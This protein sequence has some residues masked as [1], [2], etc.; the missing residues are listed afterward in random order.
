VRCRAVV[1][2]WCCWLGEGLGCGSRMGVWRREIVVVG[3]R[4]LYLTEGLD[5]GDI[6]SHHITSHHITARPAGFSVR[7]PVP[8]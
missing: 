1:G 8:G 5:V 4:D 6:T 3:Y 2:L 7:S